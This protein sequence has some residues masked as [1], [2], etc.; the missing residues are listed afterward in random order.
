MV[1][2]KKISI[3]NKLISFDHDYATDVLEKNAGLAQESKK[4]LKERGI[5]FQTPFTQFQI[6]WSSLQK[7]G[8]RI[9]ILHFCKKI[10]MT[11]SWEGG[12]GYYDTESISV[13]IGIS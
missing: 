2:K 6:H 5:R 10:H 1:L 11:E 12:G 4:H 8:K 9:L 7:S 13:L 3:G